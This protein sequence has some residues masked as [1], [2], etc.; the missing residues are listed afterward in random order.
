M[1]VP[2]PQGAA[3]PP[4]AAARPKA[5]ASAAT[6]SAGGSGGAAVPRARSSRAAAGR[7]LL[8]ALAVSLLS[9]AAGSPGDRSPAFRRCHSQC[10]HTGCATIMPAARGTPSSRPECSPLCGGGGGSGGSGGASGAVPAAL[11]LLRWDCAADCSYLCMWLVES[12]RPRGTPVQKY[13]GK[14]PFARWAGLQEPASV[15]FS[16]ANL[17]AH[18]HCLARFRALRRRL[19]APQRRSG[20]P[21][22]GAGGV[23][24]AGSKKSSAGGGAAAAAGGGGAAYAWL[25]RGYMLLSINA[26]LWSAAFHARDTRLTERLDYFAAAALIFFNLFLAV[27]RTARLRAPAALAA[28]AAPLAAFLAAHFRHMLFVLFD[29]GYHMKVCIAAG[30][31]QSALWV[32]WAA[33]ARPRPAGRRALLA[34]LAA[35]HACMLLEVL[36]FPPLWHVLDAHSLW[37]AATA[38]LV[39]LFYRFIEADCAAGA[40]HAAL[41][42][43]PRRKAD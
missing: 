34:F 7:T 2:T 4:P 27:A 41:P 39:Y 25:W 21:D 23:S 30:L 29:Y 16:L 3:F 35:V 9:S 8:L 12:S 22:G 26:W 18:A 10:L 20:K 5:A 36:D 13:H 6:S 19:A 31:A 38:P 15:A 33:A 17:A 11:R 28:A 1:A 40:G 43:L 37:H 24:D 32:A 42:P 14:W